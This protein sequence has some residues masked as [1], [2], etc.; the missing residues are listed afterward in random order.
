MKKEKIEIVR[1]NKIDADLD[2]LIDLHKSISENNKL[3]SHL[4][5]YDTNFKSY[6]EKIIIEPD[7]N[8]I[9]KLNVNNSL[10][11]FIHFKLLKNTIFLNNICLEKKYQGKGFAK[12]F[13]L[14]SLNLL[15]KNDLH[16][17]SLDV[18]ISNQSAFLWYTKLGLEVTKSFAWKR[19]LANKNYIDKEPLEEM[20]FKKDSNGFNSLFFKDS[21]VAT[22]INNSTMLLHDLTSINQMPLNNYI[23]ITNQ[24]TEFLEKGNFKIIDLDNALR[25]LC[26]MTIFSNNLIK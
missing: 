24:D 12:Y 10:A 9:F 15:N 1:Y 19:I 26:P 16:Y 6:F 4:I 7:F 21:K 3:N 8:Y 11:G 2:K 14:K 20:I 22:I 5:Y 23:L 17:F 25:M 18:F 13:L